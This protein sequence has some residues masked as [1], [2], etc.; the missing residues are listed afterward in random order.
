MIGVEGEAGDFKVTLVKKPRYIIEDKCTGCTTC[1]KYCPVQYPDPFNQEIS[2]N[3]AVHVFFSQ[4]IPLVAYIDE[5]CLFLKEKKCDICRSV[6]Q[7][8]AIDFKQ[9]T[10]KSEVNVG[11][12]I[13]ASALSR[14]IPG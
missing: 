4:A 9:K 12:I 6:C 5:S 8:G 13:L 7:T 2:T 1:M 3:K 11:A 10:E 14:L